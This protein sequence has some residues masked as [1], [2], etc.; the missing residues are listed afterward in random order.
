MCYEKKISEVVKN[1]DSEEC[2]KECLHDKHGDKWNLI[3]IEARKG[4]SNNTVSQIKCTV[5]LNVCGERAKNIDKSNEHACCPLCKSEES[6]EHALLCGKYNL[7]SK[8]NIWYKNKHD[9]G[10]HT[11]SGFPN[12]NST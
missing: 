3:D 1:I 8:H 9:F 6:W 10:N 2:I 7:F 11:F 12:F 4:F 5:G